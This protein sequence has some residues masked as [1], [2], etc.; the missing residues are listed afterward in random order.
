MKTNK[1]LNITLSFV[2]IIFTCMMLSVLLLLVLAEPSVTYW[3]KREFL[4]DNYLIV[5]WSLIFL[6]VSFYFAEKIKGKSER[7]YKKLWQNFCKKRVFLVVSLFFFLIQLFIALHIYFYPGWDVIY[8]VQNAKWLAEGN[9]A[10]LSNKY[11]SMYNNNLLLVY[12]YSKLFQVGQL[13]SLTEMKDMMV[14]FVFLQCMI[15]SGTGMLVFGCVDKL[16]GRISFAWFAW[17]LYAGLILISPWVVVPYSDSVGLFMPLSIFYL[18]ISMK[19]NK[20]DIIRWMGIALLSYWGFRIKPQILI[21]TIAIIIIEIV[22]KITVKPSKF[23]IKSVLACACILVVS[24]VCFQSMINSM[25][26][27]LDREKNFGVTHFLMMGLNT[28]SDGGYSDKDVQ[29]S[30][31]FSTI[32]ERKAGNVKKIQKRVENFNEKGWGMHL[33]KKTLVNYGDGS[34]S[35]GQEGN[36]NLETYNQS[37]TGK[38]LQEIYYEEGKYFPVLSTFQHW[39]WMFVLTC[40]PL[41]AFFWG[42]PSQIAG[43]EISVLMLAIIGLSLFELMFEARSRYFYIYA[44]LY[45]L[46]AVCGI[47][48]AQNNARQKNE[49]MFTKTLQ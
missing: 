37:D 32:E 41:V 40:L 1:I 9:L 18:Y 26:F 17:I 3:Y 33:I 20:Y 24:Q 28:R 47:C 31:K 43:K 8:V 29:F 21:V 38:F 2:Q 36:F 48:N 22:H 14:V 45:I 35:F 5:I 25:P 30:K 42:N 34:F 15:S 7:S 11:F 6:G 4:L 44:P 39:I 23:G 46:L 19:G 49:Q 12:L 16:L 13:F 27:T 10:E